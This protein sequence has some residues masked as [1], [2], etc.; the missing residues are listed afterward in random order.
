MKMISF[1]F[2]LKNWLSELVHL[3]CCR[4][5]VRSLSGTIHYHNK[6]YRPQ[7]GGICVANHTSPIDVLILATDGCYAMVGI[8]HWCFMCAS[9][10]DAN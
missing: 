5:C 3:T 8:A 2:S 1:S 10:L 6:Q 7:K 9:L 4:I